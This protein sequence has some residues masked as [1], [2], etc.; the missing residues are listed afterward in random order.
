MATSTRNQ[1]EQFAI[2]QKAFN[3]YFAATVKPRLGRPEG[4]LAWMDFSQT[5][6][7]IRD[8]GIRSQYRARAIRLLEAS[9]SCSG[10]NAQPMARSTYNATFRA[11]TTFFVAVLAYRFG[12]GILPALLAAAIWYGYVA[13]EHRDV[14]EAAD[15]HDEQA[16]KW[17]EKISAWEADLLTLKALE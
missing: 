11:T 5:A 17:A 2:A 1:Y 13:G 4:E 10:P 8:T 7:L 16:R 6:K 15:K 9:I 12:P 3:E 14:Q